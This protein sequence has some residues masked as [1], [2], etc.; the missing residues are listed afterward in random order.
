[1]FLHLP[2]TAGTSLRII[3]EAQLGER[4]R[5]AYPPFPGNSMRALLHDVREGDVIYGH[6]VWGAHV[7]FQAEPHYAAVLRHP[8]D[9]LLSWYR[10]KRQN[11]ATDPENLATTNSLADLISAGHIELHNHMTTIVAGRRPSGPD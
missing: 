5:R 3:L 2:K 6:F 7:Q 10:F 8:V 4:L 11:P 9:R 1:F